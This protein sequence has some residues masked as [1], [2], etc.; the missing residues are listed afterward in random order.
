MQK[1]ESNFAC[2]GGKTY[3]PFLHSKE[4]T[5]DSL[6]LLEIRSL[7]MCSRLVMLP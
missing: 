6:G 7:E 3:P 1:Q 4:I 2:Q 5:I